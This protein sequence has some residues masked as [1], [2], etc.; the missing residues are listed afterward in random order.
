[1]YEEPCEKTDTRHV[2]CGLF[3]ANESGSWIWPSTVG[4][5][6]Y[7]TFQRNPFSIFGN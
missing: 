7:T 3:W 1:M 2:R 4:A 6:R 5:H